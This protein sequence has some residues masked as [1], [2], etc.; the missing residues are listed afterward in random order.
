MNS[1][2]TKNAKFS[3]L[4]PVSSRQDPS[5]PG[6]FMLAARWITVGSKRSSGRGAWIW[7]RA[8]TYRLHLMA[9]R[10]GRATS[11]VVGRR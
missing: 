4:S 9:V 8:E 10:R 7:S 2:L 11:V 1:D 6:R 5:S 3:A